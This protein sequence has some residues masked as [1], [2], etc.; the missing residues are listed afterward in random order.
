MNASIAFAAV[1]LAGATAA[2]AQV[3][4]FATALGPE[5]VG[6]TG[7]GSVSLTYD[8]SAHTLGI[9]ASWAGLS[10]TTT[11]AHIH[12]PT[13]V[14]GTGIAGVAVTPTTLPLFP[15]G[16][17]A[18]TYQTVL[19][20]AQVATYT[21]SFLSLGGS[22]VAGAE[23]LLIQSFYDGKA[24]FNIH[25]ST[26][27]GGEIRGFL[28]PVPEPGTYALMALGLVAVGGMARRRCPA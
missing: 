15:P 9:D 17:S 23:A 28:A 27:P 1:L 13:A 5:A 19:D 25:S 7:S 26:N 10:G 20:L 2:Q 6:A 16:I 18:G 12:A 24:Y 22:T 21:G 11:V 8:P 4:L 3:Q 14:A